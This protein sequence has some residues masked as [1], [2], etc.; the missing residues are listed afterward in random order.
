[1]GRCGTSRGRWQ[2]QCKFCDLCYRANANRIK[3]HLRGGNGNISG[4]KSVDPF[5]EPIAKAVASDAAVV[6]KKRSATAHTLT[7]NELFDTDKKT[8]A[9]LAIAELVFGC[10]LPFNIART[11]FLKRAVTAINQAPKGYCPPS[12]ESLRT[13]LLEETKTRCKA[14]V[15]PIYKDHARTG[16]TLCSDGWGDITRHHLINIM[17]VSPKGAVF[18]CAEECTGETKS[19][20][21]ISRLLIDAI[22]EIGPQNI[23][24]VLKV[25]VISRLYVHVRGELP[26]ICARLRCTANLFLGCDRLCRQL[27]DSTTT[28]HRGISTHHFQCMRNAL[29]RSVL[30]G[31]GQAGACHRSVC[32]HQGCS[33]VHQEP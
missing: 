4:C 18:H 3:E 29:R 24:Q 19:G 22:K 26:C 6:S 1:L 9:D 33:P 21:F 12:S 13:S 32:R 5:P 15:E 11:K 30:G 25:T 31:Y 17:V 10:G 28:C 16:A 7:I 23:V 27:Q 14:A 20:I 2:V 8:A